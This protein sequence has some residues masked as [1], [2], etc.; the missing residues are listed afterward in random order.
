MNKN[1]LVMLQSLPLEIKVAKS[2]SKRY[3]ASPV[4]NMFSIL[5]SPTIKYL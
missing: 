3:P 5:I 4:S 2:K 1:E